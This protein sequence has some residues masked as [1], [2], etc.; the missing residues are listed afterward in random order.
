MLVFIKFIIKPYITILIHIVFFISKCSCE[1]L[2]LW[3]GHE[4]LG[5]EIV[6]HTDFVPIPFLPHQKLLD[7]SFRLFWY[8]LIH[9][10][11]QK[12][13]WRPT[14]SSFGT[15]WHLNVR[16]VPSEIKTLSLHSTWGF[17]SCQ[18][19]QRHL[20]IS[21]FMK[22]CEL[23]SDSW[24]ILSQCAKILSHSGHSPHLPS[25]VESCSDI[26]ARPC[27]STARGRIAGVR[28]PR[29]EPASKGQAHNSVAA[30]LN[31][32]F[33]HHIHHIHH[34]TRFNSIQLDSTRFNYIAKWKRS[35]SRAQ[36]EH[37]VGAQGFLKL[38]LTWTKKKMDRPWRRL[39][40][41]DSMDWMVSLTAPS[42]DSCAMFEHHNE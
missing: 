37:G 33:I 4:S 13:L 31:S 18:M 10:D 25:K 16:R 27:G 22:W 29:D 38:E 42:S 20:G 6:C 1:G 19:K 12:L 28:S 3:H 36:I 21:C 15:P 11:Q 30:Q 9:S 24:E 40:W 7:V 34:S 41:G 5:K 26:G 2:W 39:W 23:V 14:P 8:V 32:S 17:G 35:K